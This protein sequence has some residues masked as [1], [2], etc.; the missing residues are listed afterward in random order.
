MWKKIP[1]PVEYLK[2]RSDDPAFRRWATCF[3]DKAAEKSVLMRGLANDSGVYANLGRAGSAKGPDAFRKVFY[4]MSAMC[5][6]SIVDLGDFSPVSTGSVLD[7]HNWVRANGPKENYSLITSIG[8]GHDWAAVDFDLPEMQIVHIDTH[9]DVRPYI[10]DKF[11]SGMPFRYLAEKGAKIW[12]F[13]AQ[14]EL[15]SAEHW[16]YAE[17]KFK[18]LYSLDELEENPAHAFDRCFTEIDAQKPLGLSIDLDAFP[19]AVSPG[20]SAPNPRGISLT[21]VTRIIDAV[22]K[23]LSHVGIYEL[24]PTF[25][26]DEQTARVGAYLLSRIL[27]KKFETKAS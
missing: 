20:V 5:D 14:R 13:G 6:V 27:M 3:V 26:K 12:C 1:I 23:N 2:A 7:Y 16:D 9:L 8:G 21:H 10:A 22:A 18:G 25:D 17:S 11:H 4:R 19:Q 24:N 15:H